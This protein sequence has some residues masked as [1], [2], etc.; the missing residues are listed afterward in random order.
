MS[1]TCVDNTASAT[2]H[3]SRFVRC[4]VYNKPK[5]KFVY[6]SNHIEHTDI[7]IHIRTR[8]CVL[9]YYT[10]AELARPRLK[11]MHINRAEENEFEKWFWSFLQCKIKLRH[12][13]RRSSISFSTRRSMPR[14]QQVAV[15]SGS[16]S[17]VRYSNARNQSLCTTDHLHQWF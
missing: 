7:H 14:G 5:V 1:K 16:E 4:S 9:F 10:H 17:R 8:K 2:F 6:S 3:W 11:Y 13:K 15:L 12:S